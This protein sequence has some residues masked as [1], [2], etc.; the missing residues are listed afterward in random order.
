MGEAEAG[1]EVPTPEAG[2]GEDR[3]ETSSVTINLML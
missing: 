1:E 3:G 2:A